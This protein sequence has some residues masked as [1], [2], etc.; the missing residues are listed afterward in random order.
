MVWPDLF[1]PIPFHIGQARLDGAICT[2]TEEEKMQYLKAAFEAGIRNIEMESSVF[3]AMCNI[4]GLRGKLTERFNWKHD[5]TNYLVSKIGVLENI[6][7]QSLQWGGSRMHSQ[8]ICTYHF[9]S[10]YYC[11]ALS[12]KVITLQYFF[13]FK[14][15]F[16]LSILIICC[17]DSHI[18]WTIKGFLFLSDYFF[19]LWLLIAM[20]YLAVCGSFTC[21]VYLGAVPGLHC[22]GQA[23]NV[24]FE[25][26]ILH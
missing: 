21:G 3:A 12:F 8:G 2:Y 15:L 1:F 7:V 22:V 25:H 24:C 20:H 16:L 17:E 26:W 10:P 11:S 13:Q 18:H 14:D 23:C 5:C 9:Q 6:N 4:C 19:N